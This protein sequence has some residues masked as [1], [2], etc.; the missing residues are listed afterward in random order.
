MDRRKFIQ[1][2]GWTML[3]VAATGSL[4]GS[5]APG[6]KEAKKIMPSPSNLKMF[7]GDLHNHCNL[8]YG[9]GDMRDAFEAAKGQLDF[10]SVTPHAMWPDIPGKNDPRLSWVIDYHTD[11]FKR[12]RKGGYKKYQEMTKEYNKEGEFLTFIGYE[13]HSMQHGDHVA[14]H[15]DLD[16][17]LVE[18]ESI[19]DWKT[20]FDLTDGTLAD[21]QASYDRT[22][23]LV[24]EGMAKID[25]YL[26]NRLA[27]TEQHMMQ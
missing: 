25:A 6:S 18:C 8:T 16:A 1:T 14:L 17:P 4:L 10:V 3:G 19:E 22:M 24:G 26:A 23:E 27:E 13:A 9:H 11:A 12:L 2:S 15:H 5:C 20:T 7:W 21:A